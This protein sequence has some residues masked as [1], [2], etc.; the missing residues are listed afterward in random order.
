VR[1]SVPV[2]VLSDKTGLRLSVMYY[3]CGEGNL[4]ICKV[5]N[6]V[7]DIPIKVDASATERAVR[8]SEPPGAQGGN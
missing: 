5:K 2:A 6:R 3:E 4:G 8:L 7:W 1:L